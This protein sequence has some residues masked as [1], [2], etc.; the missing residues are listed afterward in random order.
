[1]R[2][3]KTNGLN[4]LIGQQ[5][6]QFLSIFVRNSV[7]SMPWVYRKAGFFFANDVAGGVV[8]TGVLALLNRPET[9]EVTSSEALTLPVFVVIILMGYRFKKITN[10][11]I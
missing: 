4:E 8:F 5:A 2:S 6:S 7:V 11:L 9:M 3:S 10:T 1:M